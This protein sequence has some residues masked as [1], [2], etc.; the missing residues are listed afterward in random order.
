MTN[1]DRI[2]AVLTARGPLSDSELR[3]LSGVEPHQQVNQICRRLEAQDVLRRVRGA[4]G[5]IQNVL[6][7]HPVG[8]PS[9]VTPPAQTPSVTPSRSVRA[10][11][12]PGPRIDPDGALLVIPCSGWKDRGGVATREGHSVTDVLPEHL[13]HRLLEA[14][15]RLRP[16]AHMDESRFLPAWR[17]YSGH[18][19]RAAS[20]TLERLAAAGG[21]VV[22]ISGGYGLVLLDE[23]IG[24]YK[25]AFALRD[26]PAGL[27]EACLASLCSGFGADW[28]L[29]FCARTTGY[30]ALVR[31]TQNRTGLSTTI[32]SP[33]LHGGGAQVLVPRASGEAL[34]AALEG[35]L[36]ATWA[37]N[38]GLIV[39]ATALP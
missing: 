3:V 17:R 4:D 27:L 37:S 8:T 19:Y 7:E 2:V 12:E 1:A 35:R 9:D 21:P 29:A 5:R 38:D 22:I 13:A 30:A 14:R 33:E 26:W 16:K 24:S 10:V 11:E 18:F 23:P 39:K 28:I 32:A 25:R 6:T 31:S 36:T 20:S 34:A 15:A